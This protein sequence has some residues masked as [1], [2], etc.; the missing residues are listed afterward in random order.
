MLAAQ[1]VGGFAAWTAHLLVSGGVPMGGSVNQGLSCRA[2][3][4]III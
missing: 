3:F 1:F 2:C 4:S